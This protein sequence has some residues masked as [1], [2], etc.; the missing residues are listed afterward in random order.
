MLAASSLLLNAIA[1][2]A[3]EGA[4][5]SDASTG[6]D[7]FTQALASL[8][9]V[10]GHVAPPTADPTAPAPSAAPPPAGAAAAAQQDFL[11]SL[12]A[13]SPSG[14]AANAQSASTSTLGA[15]PIGSNS[16]ASTASVLAS[17]AL[18]LGPAA[19]SLQTLL[20]ASA[21]AQG[22]AD[23]LDG[24]APT[25]GAAA[26]PPPTEDDTAMTAAL[27]KL[28]NLAQPGAGETAP[29]QVGPQAQAAAS[30]STAGGAAAAAA[31]A[32]TA[33]GA[34]GPAASAPALASILAMLSG[35]SPAA[36]PGGAASTSSA[37]GASTAQAPASPDTQDAAIDPR[38]IRFVARAILA[39]AA[40]A[41]PATATTTA[42][43]TTTTTATTTA[44]AAATTAAS[45]AGADATAVAD[46]GQ[47]DATAALGAGPASGA[48]GI[49]AETTPPPPTLDPAVLVAVAPGG[50]Q[51]AS[52]SPQPTPVGGKAL[53]S[54]AQAQ[55]A[56]SIT[57]LAPAVATPK[58]LVASL[59]PA[60]ADADEPSPDNLAASVVAPPQDQSAPGPASGDSIAQMTAQ[61]AAPADL[62]SGAAGLSPAS[63]S[64]ASSHG[65]EITA[66]LAAQIASRA[67][68]A[69]SAFDFS[70]D[71]QGL[72]R[73]D[74]S[75]KIDPQGGLSA[76]LS[77][78]NSAT[79]AEAK[80]RAGELQ[81]ALQQAG[82]DVSH[83]GLSFTSGGQG[84]GADP[85]AAA[86]PIYGQ[87]ASGADTAAALAAT[88]SQLASASRAGG[89]DITI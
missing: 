52:L 48:S 7:A 66:Q 72:G 27:L 1:N 4:S 25:S 82:F 24:A 60:A 17:L 58:G 74:V 37:A 53:R 63:A 35:G 34:G 26:P 32:A 14:A 55:T 78:D 57:T 70:L 69:H 42:A 80:S 45:Q 23:P 77:F 84:R 64:L 10:L 89:V 36:T 38:L 65:V 6:G 44:T 51:P 47:T 56:T 22:D 31:P 49:A 28:A 61:A 9:A 67:S 75:L 2:P 43:T 50:P 12:A 81:Q 41:A 18:S 86:Q 79:A 83:G 88:Q 21:G 20:G 5:V 68:A 13:T 85:Q 76:V 62:A 8:M 73:V 71:P 11:L 30:A 46:D 54:A 3:G 15:A 39:E 16:T 29:T 19:Q 40:P 87:A 33:T 59:F